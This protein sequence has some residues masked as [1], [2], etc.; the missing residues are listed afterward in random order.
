MPVLTVHRQV[1]YYR[2][3]RLPN[4]LPMNETRTHFIA[5][6]PNCSASL[7]VNRKHIGQDVIC[8]HCKHTFRAGKTDEPITPS[9]GEGMAG[10]SI[11]PAPPTDRIAVQCPSCQTTLSVR[12]VYIGN[13]VRCKQCGDT[14]IVSVPAQPQPEPA[15]SA[16]E[17]F[18]ATSSPQRD[19]ERESHG[20]ETERETLRSQHD[21]L[22]A[23]HERLQAAHDQL[24]AKH[25][26]LKSEL[27][28]LK[29]DNE[30]IKTGDDLLKT[31]Y[32]RLS[33]HTDRLTTELDTIRACLD[34]ISPEEVRPLAEERESLTAEVKRLRVEIDSLLAERPARAHLT[35]ELAHRD[36]E[37]KAARAE[38]DLLTKQ[39]AQ[40]DN[41]LKAA[42]A[43]RDLLTK[44]IAQ[45]DNELKAARAERDLLTE[46][47]AQR[48]KDLNGARAERDLLTKQIS[49]GDD[50]LEAARIEQGRLSIERKNVLKEVEQLRS[51][52]EGRDQAMR[53][54]TE[55]LIAEVEGLRQALGLAEQTHRD[56]R[57]QLSAEL[58]ALGARHRQ[59][60]DQHEAAEQSSREYQDR[61]QELMEAH[62]RLKSD[63]GSLLD[64]GRLQQERWTEQLRE[65]RAHSDE[66]A[67]LAA[68]A[69]S[70][71]LTPASSRPNA[72]GELQA[73][74]D[75]VANLKRQL[76]ES[77]RFNRQI[78]DVLGGIG[79]NYK[80]LKF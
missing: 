27:E 53:S 80:T 44:Q 21:Q 55:S 50:D 35:A 4:I 2:D 11:Q 5:V 72:D 32:A 60:Q 18:L 74:R 10:P 71:K 37:L 67:R 70:E 48:D 77:E 43:E 33:E 12:R 59:L 47:I 34:T 76:D 75:E 46:Q 58:T 26:G 52:L 15:V 57:D 36:G 54:A 45:R 79:I 13:Q 65:L 1:H 40:R 30:R 8:N 7:R 73:A 31:E 41:E 28:R 38:R 29:T 6:C 19:I 22:L 78:S 16:L 68:P 39:I 61:N 23:D 9:S 3:E 56:D 25:N 24:D 51:A 20:T 69:P 62:A 66:T 49:Q 42:R 64:S 17:G 14:F 63:Y